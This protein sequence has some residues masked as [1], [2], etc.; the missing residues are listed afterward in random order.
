MTDIAPRAGRQPEPGPDLV[1]IGCGSDRATI[2]EAVRRPLGRLI[3]TRIHEVGLSQDFLARHL[4]ISRSN[5]WH[6]LSGDRPFSVTELCMVC[7]LL[8]CHID[9]LV[10]VARPR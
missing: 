8:G 3:A 6:R 5:L 9:E 4:G 10:Y 1:Y 7:V 2:E